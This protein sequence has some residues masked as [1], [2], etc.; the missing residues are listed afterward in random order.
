VLTSAH[1]PDQVAGLKDQGMLPA[2][3]TALKGLARLSVK[4]HAAMGRLPQGFADLSSLTE[5][6][7][8]K[9]GKLS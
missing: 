6:H 9:V 3:I 1:K 4:G 2:N 7:F 8:E 5:L